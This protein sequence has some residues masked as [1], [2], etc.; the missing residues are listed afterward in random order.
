MRSASLVSLVITN[1]NYGRFLGTA[2]ESALGQTYPRTE[3][4]VV[5]DGSTDDSRAVMARY[6]NRLTTMFKVN[7][8]Q[9]STV[10]AGF[11][12]SRGDVVLFL[13]ADDFLL[14]TAAEAVVPHF[15]D[16]AVVKVHWPLWIV[17]EEG[18]R[19]GALLPDRPLAD[20]NLREVV[21]RDGPDSYQ[22]AP[23]SGNAWSRSFLSNVLPAPEAEYRYGTDGYL[24]TL[25]PLHGAMHTL[26]EPLSCYRVHG[27]NQYWCTAT[28]ERISR[29]LIRYEHRSLTLRQHLHAAGVA[30]DPEGWK[31]RNEYYQWMSRLRQATAE[32]KAVIPAGATF[33]LADEC[34]WG[35]EVIT[36][37]RSVPFPERDGQYGGPPADDEAA[38]HEFERLRQAGAGFMVFGWPAFWWLDCYSALRQLLYSQYRCIL[39]DERLVVFD[40]R[41]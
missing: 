7:G 12:R 9:A 25:A 30:S 24:I 37:R 28:D 21:V 4:I 19:T 16:P 31:R 34:Q 15:D 18:K 13:D 36:G 8:G 33:I 6:G 5:D 23:T 35:P 39:E 41:P 26:S 22:G 2:I 17:D 32:L 14:P 11:A 40:L 3:V 27:Q 20:G 10:N 29:S 1:Y 38:I